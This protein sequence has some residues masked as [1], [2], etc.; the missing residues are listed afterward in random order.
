MAMNTSLKNLLKGSLVGAGLAVCAAAPAQAAGFSQFTFDTYTDFSGDATTDIMLQSV[1]TMGGTSISNF[2]LV[3]DANIV[4]NTISTGSQLGPGSSDAGD[5]AGGTVNELPDN[6]DI[7]A[8]LG[9]LNLNNIIDTEDKKGKSIFDVTF[10]S[11]VN[12]FF[13]FE[14][15]LNSDLHVEALDS[16]GNV[17]ADTAFEI[18]RDL[19]TD[20]GY[21][22]DTTEITAAQNVGSYGLKFGREVAGLRI[23]SFGIMDNGPDYKVVAAKTP[24]PGSMAALGMVAG[25]L[26]LAQRRRKQA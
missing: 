8:S 6:A 24:E 21:Q 13:L 10:D 1:T 15:G 3:N 20:A 2:N 19:W 22:I 14:R 17:I 12:T 4:A 25:S 7:V 26:L 16:L 18:T 5:N 23:S 11:P 9:N